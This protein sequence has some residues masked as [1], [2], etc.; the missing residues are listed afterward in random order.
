M[1]FEMYF[2]HQD[3]FDFSQQQQVNG[4]EIDIVTFDSPSSRGRR[5]N[6]S[7]TRTAYFVDEQDNEAGEFVECNV[8]YLIRY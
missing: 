5:V 2:L 8:L 3:K 1:I 7:G 6:F 4:L